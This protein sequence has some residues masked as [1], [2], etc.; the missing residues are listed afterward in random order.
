VLEAVDQVRAQ[1]ETLRQR[2]REARRALDV[3]V[4]AVASDAVCRR[5]A[6]SPTLARAH[7]VALYAAIEREIDLAPLARTLLARG[8]RVVYPRVARPR[9]TFHVV[10]S[11]DEL[12]PDRWGIPTPSAT[13][14]T[15]GSDE[16]DALLVPALAFDRRGHR[17]GYGRGYYDGE[18]AAAPRALR[19]GIAHEMQLVDELPVGAT[20]EPVD[21]IITERGDRPTGA[22]PHIELAEVES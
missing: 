5:L 21:W 4:A 6:A 7:T 12:S 11:L 2:M 20:D 16:L 13:A 8:V 1:K 19:I 10:T 14:P 9:L 17:L 3:E 18:L 15:V 22:R